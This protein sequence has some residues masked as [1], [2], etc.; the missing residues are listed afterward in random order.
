M[1]PL[2]TIHLLRDCLEPFHTVADYFGDSGPRELRVFFSHLN[3]CCLLL[4]Q[5]LV[6]RQSPS[7][8]WA[9]EVGPLVDPVLKELEAFQESSV[10]PEYESSLPP[11]IQF[12]KLTTLIH[13]WRLYGDDSR[14]VHHVRGCLD[15]YCNERRYKIILLLRG[16]AAAL[17]LQ[18]PDNSHAREYRTVLGVTGR[19]SSVSLSA[20]TVFQ[21]LFSSAR[22]CSQVHNHQSAVGLRIATHRKHDQDRC[23]FEGLVTLSATY[24]S[25]QETHINVDI[26][27]SPVKER[28]SFSDALTHTNHSAKGPK[29][30]R[31]G[32]LEVVRLCEQID[33]LRKMPSMCLNLWVEDGKLWKDHSLR[34]EHPIH[35]PKLQV[36]LGDIIKS[37]PSCL[38]EKMKRVLSVLLAYSVLHLHGTP[39]LRP[40]NFH[41]N[42]IFF[43]GTST[44]IPLKPYIQTS[45]AE[46]V[47]DPGHTNQDGDVDPD[48]LPLHPHPEI[49]MLAI[50]LIELYVVQQLQPFASQFGVGECDSLELVDENTRYRFAIAAFDRF[51]DEFPDNYREA[52]DKCLDPNIA[53]GPDDEELNEQAFKQ[54]IY[55]GIV[56]P[57]EDELHQGFGNT[58]HIDELDDIVQKMDLNSGGQIQPT[59]PS[60]PEFTAAS[61]LSHNSLT[62]QGITAPSEEYISSENSSKRARF[63]HRDY[64]VGWICALPT[65]LA[66]AQAV[67]DVIHPPLPQN[68]ADQ[69]NYSLG[70]IGSHNVVMACLPAGVIGTVSAA[71]VADNMMATFPS[72]KF[73]LLVGI[74]GGVPGVKDVRLGDVVVGEPTG[75]FGGIIQYDFGKTVRRGEFHRTGSLNRPPD[76]L[77]TAVSRLMADHLRKRPI[78]DK[79]LT[80]IVK[81]YPDMRSVYSHPGV[82][83]DILFA[84]DYDHD[85]LR[86]GSFCDGCDRSKL[87]QRQP[88]LSTAPHIHYGLIASGNRVMRDGKTRD[89]LR[90]GHDILCFEMEA[91][92]IVDSFPCLVIRGICDYSD[93]HKN[94]AWQGYAAATAAAYA[95]ELL[96]VIVGT[97]TDNSGDWTLCYGSD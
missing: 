89:K 40:S 16:C 68:A 13:Y 50:M 35:R 74:G 23:R 76:V 88:R 39:W 17:Q 1:M 48:D 77:L 2:Q 79:Y 19:P 20:N 75:P 63:T 53:L 25:W 44:A 7:P 92:G 67:L 66:A 3:A 38:T 15:L 49:V 51:K 85:T 34:I 9:A 82:E 60:L 30:R 54:L 95:K 6:P 10:L 56:Q 83:H 69:N 87:V 59:T 55:G 70:R 72:L 58:V 96:S 86:D 57:L 26:F 47:D 94:K 28:S 97:K 36:S 29:R 80:E 22:A 21:A 91:A 11:S 37:R 71:R 62:S 12:P 52:V 4:K 73:G 31:L 65:E 43:Y 32:R 14:T 42:N 5:Y 18:H 46:T 78:L 41:P 61:S 27:G 33:K 64:T 45:L 90:D 84:S 93:S 24:N 81:K 8:E